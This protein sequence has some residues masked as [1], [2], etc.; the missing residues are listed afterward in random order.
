MFT[1]DNYFPL[2]GREHQCVTNTITEYVNDEHVDINNEVSNG[3][4]GDVYADHMI[5][6]YYKVTVDGESGDVEKI[7]NQISGTSVDMRQ[8]FYWYLSSIGYNSN[9]TQVICI[10]KQWVLN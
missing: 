4:H 5:L 2:L 3:Y 8:H 9:S 7:T 1:D 10:I 6:Q